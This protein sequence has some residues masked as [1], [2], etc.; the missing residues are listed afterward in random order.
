MIGGAS[1]G[2]L[3]K[4]PQEEADGVEAQLG[5]VVGLQKR[6]E[7]RNEKKSVGSVGRKGRGAQRRGVTCN[8]CWKAF[9]DG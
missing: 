7:T 2:G 4:Q 5:L 3:T 6:R 8:A 9:S 1:K